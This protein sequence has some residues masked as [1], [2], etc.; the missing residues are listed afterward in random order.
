MCHARCPQVQPR[1]EKSAGV[2]L[3]IPKRHWGVPPP[4]NA[5]SLQQCGYQIPL[6]L[7]PVRIAATS[8]SSSCSTRSK[9]SMIS[10]MWLICPS[11]SVLAKE[12]ANVSCDLVALDDQGRH[13]AAH[14]GIAGGYGRPHLAHFGLAASMTHM[15]EDI[16]RGVGEEFDVV[17]AACQR[18]FNVAG[19][20]HV[21][22]LQH[23]LTVRSLGHSSLP[24]L[25][26]PRSR[27]QSIV[28]ATAAGSISKRTQTI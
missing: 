8:R 10:L 5:A 15:G 26:R 28:Q 7:R 20:Q 14:L 13:L 6:D 9:V 12:H 1:R 23:A 27:G 17:G 19:V 25:V 18:A 16:D 22:E 24:A 21:E 3:C 4:G 11:R 2:R